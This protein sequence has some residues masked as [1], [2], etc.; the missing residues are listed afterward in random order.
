MQNPNWKSQLGRRYKGCELSNDP[1]ASSREDFRPSWYYW[2]CSI[3]QGPSTSQ[4]SASWDLLRG[5]GAI[6]R[7]RIPRP[8][9]APSDPHTKPARKEDFEG[10]S[11][12]KRG[13]YRQCRVCNPRKKMGRPREA[14]QELSVNVPDPASRSR[15]S[16][17]RALYSCSKCDIPTCYKSRCWDLHLTN[18]L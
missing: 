15:M 14:L 13:T 16:M 1:K 10:H 17:H 18:P 2:S 11:W 5:P 3:G 12:V 6:L 8:S 7:Q 9:K 4:T